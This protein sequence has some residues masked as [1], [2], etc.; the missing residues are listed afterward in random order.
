MKRFITLLLAAGLL[1]TSA[2][3]GDS[4]CK[5]QAACCQPAQECC[6]DST[7]ASTAENAALPVAQP[8][9]TKAE[10]EASGSDSTTA[11]DS[12]AKTPAESDDDC[13]SEGGDCCAEGAGCCTS[14]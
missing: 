10:G 5:P 13:C 4:C 3:A 1:T 7:N 9:S 11:R 2:F 14:G 6:V 12:S 8:I